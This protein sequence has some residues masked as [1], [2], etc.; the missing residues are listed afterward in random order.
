[1]LR[2]HF[3]R[4]VQCTQTVGRDILQTTPLSELKQFLKCSWKLPWNVPFRYSPAALAI[5]RWKP[6]SAVAQVCM[7]F[8]FT[9]MGTQ[10]RK[11]LLPT[12]RKEAGPMTTP[13]GKPGIE[14]SKSWS[15][16]KQDSSS[17]RIQLVACSAPE[18][19]FGRDPDSRPREVHRPDYV[20]S[21]FERTIR[22]R[23]IGIKR[24]FPAAKTP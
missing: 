10:H 12:C 4:P 1:M 5:L 2:S 13:C 3:H 9:G 8:C 14:E 7:F 21:G 11:P 18:T 19:L 20:E 17:K 24:Q 23:V 22:V 6:I 16:L 15:S